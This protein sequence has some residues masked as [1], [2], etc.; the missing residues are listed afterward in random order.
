[1]PCS[2]SAVE[3]G[4]L[5][6]ILASDEERAREVLKRFSGDHQVELETEDTNVDEC[7]SLWPEYATFVL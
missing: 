7:P 4:D 2:S 6:I 3:T 1:M 5:A